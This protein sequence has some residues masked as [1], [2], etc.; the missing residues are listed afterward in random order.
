MFRQLV[1]DFE[2]VMLQLV[3][4]K[5]QRKIKICIVYYYIKFCYC[6]FYQTHYITHIL[7]LKRINTKLII[8]KEFP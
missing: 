5:E 8:L 1:K 4:K 2:L 7:F 3:L 6:Y